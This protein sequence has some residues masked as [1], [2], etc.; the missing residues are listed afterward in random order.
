M[1]SE[2]L[3]FKD[4]LLPIVGS[5]KEHSLVSPMEA[6]ECNL[7]IKNINEISLNNQNDPQNEI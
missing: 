5:L 2:K 3:P 1:T 7:L 4:I 6:E